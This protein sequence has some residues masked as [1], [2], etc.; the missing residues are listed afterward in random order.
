M[1]RK[2]GRSFSLAFLLVWSLIVL[3]ADGF[4]LYGIMQGLRATTWPEAMGT[5]THSSVST[6]RGSKS[7]TYK[8]A[9]RYSYSVDGRLHEGDRHRFSGWSSSSSGAAEALVRRYPVGS[10]VTVFH[11]PDA[12]D[13][14]LER[15]ITGGDL[16]LLLF[17]LPFNLVMVGLSLDALRGRRPEDTAVSPVQKEGRLHVALNVTSPKLAG[18]YGAG[19]AGFAALLVVGIPTDFDPP[20]PVALITWGA[21]AAAG[22]YARWWMQA[23]VTSGH[24]DLVLDSRARRLSLPAISGRSARL[25]VAWDEVQAVMVETHQVKTS[26]RVRKT[27]R[28]TLELTGEDGPRRELIVDVLEPERAEAVAAWLRSQLKPGRPGGAATL[29]A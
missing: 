6:S 3:L 23:R 4:I 16:F 24:Y 29:S 19:G 15:G 13:S 5:I 10:S 7:T 20:L 27:Y 17:L 22:V 25:E 21:V 28:P 9:V 12:T 11:A 18:A 1:H 2:S 26:G 8:L 14:V